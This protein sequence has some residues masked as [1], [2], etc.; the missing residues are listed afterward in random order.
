MEVSGGRWESRRRGMREHRRQR[1]EKYDRGGKWEETTFSVPFLCATVYYLVQ[2]NAS[3]RLHGRQTMKW[4][5]QSFSSICFAFFRFVYCSLLLQKSGSE[6][7]TSLQSTQS[8][9]FME[10]FGI[11]KHEARLADWTKRHP[12]IRTNALMLL[13]I[14]A[15]GY[16]TGDINGH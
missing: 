4:L 10:M 2:E 1:E 11:N 6:R 9:R 12:A 16:I 5:P 3:E 15:S 13:V 8:P 14:Y 7:W